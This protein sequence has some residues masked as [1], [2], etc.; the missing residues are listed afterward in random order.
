ME[1]PARDVSAVLLR[2]R[3]LALP[4]SRFPSVT[5]A[6]AG[7]AKIKARALHAKKEELFKWLEDLKMELSQV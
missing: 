4:L 2:K 7:W 5:V 1:L 3:P 6:C